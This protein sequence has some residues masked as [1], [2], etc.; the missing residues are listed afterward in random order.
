MSSDIQKNPDLTRFLALFLKEKFALNICY[1]ITYL[2]AIRNNQQIP[3]VLDSTSDQRNLGEQSNS[4]HAIARRRWSSDQV[5][6]GQQRAS[7]TEH[8]GLLQTRCCL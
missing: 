4:I 2:P 8:R 3:F 6:G 5:S 7:R 1:S